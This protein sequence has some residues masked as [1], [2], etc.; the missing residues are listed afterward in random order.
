[1]AGASPS[2]PTSAG[3]VTVGLVRVLCE[4]PDGRRV[5]SGDPFRVRVY[6]LRPAAALLRALV[7]VIRGWR[8]EITRL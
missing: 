3:S 8:V 7:M 1:M 5:A 6:H 4:R 2:G